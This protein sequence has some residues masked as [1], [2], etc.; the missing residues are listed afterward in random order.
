MASLEEKWFRYHWG[1]E[2]K[3]IDIAEIGGDMWTIQH[4][5]RLMEN[6]G[7]PFGSRGSKTY[8]LYVA[9]EREREAIEALRANAERHGYWVMFYRLDVDGEAY[10]PVAIVEAGQ[11]TRVAEEARRRGWKAFCGHCRSFTPVYATQETAAPV[12]DW[13]VAEKEQSGRHLVVL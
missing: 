11:S 6:H 5:D 13:L 10:F 8:N 4:V 2:G 12:V 7:I 3:W 9:T 1:A